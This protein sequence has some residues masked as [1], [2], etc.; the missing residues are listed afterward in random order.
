MTQ[1]RTRGGKKLP[2]FVSVS[3]FDDRLVSSNV[4]NL[5][6]SGVFGFVSYIQI[7]VAHAVDEIRVLAVLAGLSGDMASLAALYAVVPVRNVFRWDWLLP[8]HS[9]PLFL[10]LQVAEDGHE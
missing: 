6:A 3:A 7:R 2:R 8:F 1:P 10:H 9:L 4:R 5:H